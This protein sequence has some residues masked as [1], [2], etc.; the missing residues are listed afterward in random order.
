[1]W[2]KREGKKPKKKKKKLRSLGTLV[3]EGI[4]HIRAPW[5]IRA[6]WHK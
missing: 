3:Y 4:I 2:K 6:P 1:L 5:G